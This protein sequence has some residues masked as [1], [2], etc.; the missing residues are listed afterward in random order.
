MEN[1]E[2]RHARGYLEIKSSLLFVGQLLT[3]K[4][5]E[6]FAGGAPSSILNGLELANFRPLF[7]LLFAMWTSQRV[8]ITDVTYEL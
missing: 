7:L 8:K 2:S 4:H 3:P 6:P 1:C 5:R